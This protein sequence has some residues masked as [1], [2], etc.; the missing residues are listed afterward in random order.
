[1]PS[2]RRIS[3]LAALLA[4]FL[5]LGMP[6]AA[7]TA[8]AV[9]AERADTALVLA[10]DVSGSVDGG[11]FGLQMEGIAKAFE[12][13]RV[14]QAILSGPRGAIVV[15]LVEWSTKPRL[16]LSWTLVASVE[17]ARALAAR[18]RMLPRVDSQFTCMSAALRFVEEKIL[19]RLPV[20]ADRT[21]I[22][23]SGDG[24]DNCNPSEPVDAVRARLVSGGAVI[25]GLPILTGEQTDTLED[26]YGEHVVGGPGSFVLAANGYDDVDRAM[27]QKFL[28][29]ISG[30]ALSEET[31][32]ASD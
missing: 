25:N 21:V 8:A 30:I 23:V 31:R 29:E 20:A 2:R 15:A 3:A 4:A 11:R 19:P 7:A 27:R 9:A 17:D 16:G 10:V 5:V 12:D 14:Q 6:S 1:M 24:V 32:V 26:W 28:M 13:A 22:D 18:I